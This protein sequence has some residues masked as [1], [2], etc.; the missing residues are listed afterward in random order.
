MVCYFFTDLCN[1]VRKL[2][3]MEGNIFNV[4]TIARLLEM[5]EE[6]LNQV[7]KSWEDDGGQLNLTLQHWSEKTGGVENLSSVRKCLKDINQEGQW[8]F[9][10]TH[11]AMAVFL[12]RFKEQLF[13]EV[14]VASSGNLARPP[15]G[16]VNIHY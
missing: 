6:V 16:E 11:H 4:V 7:T 15:S 8:C 5:P 13:T 12:K 9:K 2:L 10:R 14:E 3:G 1:Y